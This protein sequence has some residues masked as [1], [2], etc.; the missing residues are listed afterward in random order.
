MNEKK[1]PFG[2]L[3]KS[4][5][6][7]LSFNETDM[8]EKIEELGYSLGKKSGSSRQAAINMFEHSIDPPDASRKQH[9]DPPLDYV[10]A[11]AELFK[12]S[13]PEKYELFCAA[14]NSSEKIIID[15]ALFDSLEKTIADPPISDSKN[16][17]NAKLTIKDILVAVIVSLYLGREKIP[18]I[19]K[20]FL[21]NP[22]SKENK[23]SY[24]SWSTLQCA[25]DGFVDLVKR[26]A[27]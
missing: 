3:C 5:R 19:E 7:R 24:E 6:A 13:T 26:D 8:G 22:Y 23:K 1:S 16:E 2:M 27:L 12:F 4:Y 17:S 14:L 25:V 11:C 10:E 20:K 9:R 21:K 15:P 18:E